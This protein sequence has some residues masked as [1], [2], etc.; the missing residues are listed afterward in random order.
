MLR[1]GPVCRLGVLPIIVTSSEASTPAIGV[2]LC[3]KIRSVWIDAIRAA[4]RIDWVK[5]SN[6]NPLWGVLW[7][8]QSLLNERLM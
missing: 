5:C 8:A 4:I 3:W 1:L 2:V 7:G 6:G